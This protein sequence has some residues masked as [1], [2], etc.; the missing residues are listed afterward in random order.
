M[1]LAEAL[2]RGL[3]IVA[4]A[5]G[6]VADTVPAAAGLLVRSGDARALGAALRRFLTEP[7]PA[8]TPAR[9]G[10]CARASELPGW[11]D[12]AGAVEARPAAGRGMSD[13]F[14]ADWL[15]LREPY[16]A[17]ARSSALLRRGSPRGAA[18]ADVLQV[19]DLG[20]GTGSNLRCTAPALGAT[21]TGPWSSSIPR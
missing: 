1:A 11:A 8:P 13:G 15:T 9:R 10:P 20:A 12:T 5:G 6:A 3:P 4:A 17:A 14:S 18:A 19:V 7:G 2:A 21:R 16:D